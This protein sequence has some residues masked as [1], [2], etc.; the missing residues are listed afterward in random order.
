MLLAS[1]WK[2]VPPTEHKAILEPFNPWNDVSEV[3]KVRQYPDFEAMKLWNVRSGLLSP[4]IRIGIY[5]STLL[6]RQP[7]TQPG[8]W[9]TSVK[10]IDARKTWQSNK[11]MRRKK[12]WWNQS[13]NWTEIFYF[14]FMQKNTLLLRWKIGNS[15]FFSFIPPFWNPSRSSEKNDNLGKKHSDSKRSNRLHIYINISRPTLPQF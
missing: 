12:E 15:I 10:S 2:Q 5:G 13:G 7:F 8:L 4:F 9:L 3:H 1:P 14:G 6:K 11:N